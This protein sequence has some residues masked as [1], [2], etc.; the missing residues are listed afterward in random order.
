MT[1]ATPFWNA[2][3]HRLRAGWR[4]AI[5]LVATV[6]LV[7]GLGTLFSPL[8]G[9]ELTA[10]VVPLVGIT[11]AVAI[12]G[13]W[14]DHR[15]FADFGLRIDRAWW[16]D[17]VAGIGLGILLMA[18]IFGT[19]AATGWVRIDE[20]IEPEI[21]EGF[22]AGLGYAILL[23]VGVGFFEELLFR[24]YLMTN[25]AEGL[26]GRRLAPRTAVVVAWVVVSIVFGVAHAVN[27]NA[28]LVSTVNVAIAG[29]F[30]G[31]GFLLTGELALPIGLHI[32]WNFAQGAVFGF[33]VSGATIDHARLLVTTETGPDGWTGGPF[34]PEA[35]LL[36]L[37]AMLVG[38][39]ATVGWVGS[40]RRS[41]RV[42]ASIALYESWRDAAEPLG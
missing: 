34:G 40:R 29:L 12:A 4:I 13:R 14:L 5:Q 16:A 37:A 19:M 41:A 3:E 7:I 22:A 9:V 6:V 36:G 35:G 24:G 2:R 10:A 33:P 1:P 15:P 25:L 23:Y 26:A 20:A 18:A 11:A 38:S 17:L 31:L 28:T 39:A 8:V 27:P 32:A 30:V 21:A 42:A